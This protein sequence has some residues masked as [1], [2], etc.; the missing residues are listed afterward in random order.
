MVHTDEQGRRCF[1]FLAT[2][3]TEKKPAEA[4]F[5]IGLFPISFDGESA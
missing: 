5:A 1:T 3:P 4:G 2:Q